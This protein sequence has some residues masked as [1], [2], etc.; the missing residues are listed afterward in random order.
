MTSDRVCFR[1]AMSLFTVAS[2][3]SANI[4]CGASSEGGT[5]P[6]LDLSQGN[7]TAD[8]SKIWVRKLFVNCCPCIIT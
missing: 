5:K 4:G 3:L 8:G 2:I 1:L 6:R 7:I